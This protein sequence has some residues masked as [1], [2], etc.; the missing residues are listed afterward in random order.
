MAYNCHESYSVLSSRGALPCLVCLR[1]HPFLTNYQKILTDPKKPFL[2]TLWGYLPNEGEPLTLHP[3]VAEE[4]MPNVFWYWANT[5]RVL[6]ER[7]STSLSHNLTLAEVPEEMIDYIVSKNQE[8]ENKILCH[9]HQY[10]ISIFV[11]PMLAPSNNMT[12]VK[13]VQVGKNETH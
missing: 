8:I 2:D 11:A 3:N 5:M 10:C 13:W 4:Q 9:L 6:V 12:Q 1:Y 7:M